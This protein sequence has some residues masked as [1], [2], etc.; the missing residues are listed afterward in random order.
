M[1]QKAGIF[2][3]LTEP[4]RD[5]NVM[6]R[7]I[8]TVNTDYDCMYTSFLYVCFFIIKSIPL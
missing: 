5:N 2:R 3:R 8:K 4:G 1:P 7:R 6:D